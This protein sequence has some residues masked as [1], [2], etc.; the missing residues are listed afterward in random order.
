[1]G[2]GGRAVIATMGAN[3]FPDNPKNQTIFFNWFFFTMYV[4]VLMASTVVVYVEDNVSWECGF[5]VCAGANVVGLVAFLVGAPFYRRPKPEGS[6]CTGLARVVVAAITKRKLQISPSENNFYYGKD[7]LAK[8]TTPPPS[9]SFGYITN[10]NYYCTI[11]KFKLFASMPPLSFSFF[12]SEKN[13]KG[14]LN[15]QYSSDFLWFLR[16][17]FLFFF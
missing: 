6:P 3:Q 15:S 9:T 1:M 7:I 2:Q 16:C 12:K 17:Q 4:A 13:F 5:Y 11:S 8:F 14:S 10:S